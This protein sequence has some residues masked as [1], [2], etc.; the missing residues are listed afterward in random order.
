[1]LAIEQSKL[2]VDK[3]LIFVIFVDKFKIQNF[4]INIKNWMIHFDK[5]KSWNLIKYF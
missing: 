1:M 3:L 5:F 4:K 2:V